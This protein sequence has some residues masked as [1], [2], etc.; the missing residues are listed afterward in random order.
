MDVTKVT[1][2][3]NLFW[4]H[5]IVQYVM[6]QCHHLR[7]NL[8]GTLANRQD[9]RQTP[10][11]HPKVYPTLL[12]ELQIYGLTFL[13]KLR[14]GGNNNGLGTSVHCRRLLF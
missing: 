10:P 12:Q 6:A 3:T 5:G 14:P 9:H 4:K 2:M 1:T 8:N 7:Q 13:Q 11:L